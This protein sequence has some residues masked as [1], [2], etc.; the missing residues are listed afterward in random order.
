M[1]GLWMVKVQVKGTSK[2]LISFLAEVIG[3]LS[4]SVQGGG[5]PV[6]Y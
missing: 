2:N 3:K 6:I 4:D 5:K 1:S